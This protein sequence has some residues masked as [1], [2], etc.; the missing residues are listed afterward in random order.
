[1]TSMMYCSIKKKKRLKRKIPG[2]RL[3]RL[4][5]D[6][7][8]ISFLYVASKH[9]R[10]NI[11]T[12]HAHSRPQ[13]YSNNLIF[14][15][16]PFKYRY[17]VP[18]RNALEAT[19]SR[20]SIDI[21]A[22]KFA[23]RV[24]EGAR[25][26]INHSWSEKDQESYH[27]Q[28]HQRRPK[29]GHTPLIEAVRS[30]NCEIVRIL[31]QN[32]AHLDG[33]DCN[34]QSLLQVS[35]LEDPEIRRPQIEQITSMIEAARYDR[36]V[37]KFPSRL[38]SAL[39]FASRYRSSRTPKLPRDVVGLTQT[40]RAATVQSVYVMSKTKSLLTRICREKV[41][42]KHTLRHTGTCLVLHRVS[43]HTYNKWRRRRWNMMQS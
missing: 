41:T 32:G 2:I 22:Q 39:L 36:Q 19:M 26:V 9:E 43:L 10:N 4:V 18:A 20:E 13:M 7:L 35:K 29:I 28:Y 16:Q 5:G 23:H 1:M 38:S 33:Q 42:L 37:L 31:L 17:I 27:S 8:R 34:G 6:F 40:T 14:K 21:E 12:R 24:L 15:H 25:Q 11:I 3:Q 30:R